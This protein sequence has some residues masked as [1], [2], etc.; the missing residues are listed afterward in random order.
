M[1]RARPPA[2]GGQLEFH[3]LVLVT[4]G[5]VAF[6]LVMVYSA[7][8][9]R[10]AVA[11]GDPAYYLKRQAIYAALGLAAMATFARLDFRLLR[12]LGGP[13][14]LASFAALVA[15]LALGTAVN[16]ARRWLSVGLVDFQPSELAKISLALWL[17]ALLARR[18]APH[19][20]GELA[21]PIGAVVLAACV[22]ILLEPDL[23]TVVAITIMVGAILL[24]AGM[25]L[26]V[27]ASAAALGLALAAI[28][29][30][31]EPYRRAR[32]LSF[33]D[34]WADPEGSGF[35]TVQAMIALGSGG[36]FGVGLGESVQK[37]YYLPEASTDMIFAIVGEELG[38]IGSVALLAAFIAFGY[39]GFNVALRCRDPFGKLLAAGITALV[40][41]QA[42]VNL[43]AVL[44]LAPLTGIPLPFVSYGGSSLI[45]ALAAVGILLNIAV[46]HGADAAARMPDRRRGDGRARAPVPRRRRRAYSPRRTGD[47]RRRAAG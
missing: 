29:I 23:G 40:C 39:A 30:W 43:S 4:L 13:L 21:R 18:G 8:S 7:S 45:V 37:V 33:L 26:R 44:G 25:P 41:G 1:R 46:D 14:L 17:A 28:A 38:L 15:V 19:T 9:A 10:A 34:P 11:A 27:L 2:G 47:V 20:L 35:Q 3:L 42:F 16:G 5:L 32:L 6:G 22:L 24:V 12:R 31:L 36:I